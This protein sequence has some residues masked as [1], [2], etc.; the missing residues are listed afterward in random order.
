MA[1][2]ARDLGRATYGGLVSGILSVQFLLHSLRVDGWKNILVTLAAFCLIIS[3]SFNPV[4]FLLDKFFFD[5]NF[6]KIRPLQ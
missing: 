5:Q 1:W 6:L 3:E 2:S 4:R